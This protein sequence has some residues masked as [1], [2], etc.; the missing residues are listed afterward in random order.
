LLVVLLA[1]FAC[2]LALAVIARNEAIRRPVYVWIASFLAMT[3]T[4]TMTAG[5]AVFFVI[6]PVC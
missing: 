2:R 5:A 3:V 1:R 4:A 6:F